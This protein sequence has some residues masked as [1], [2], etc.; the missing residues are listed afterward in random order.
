MQQHLIYNVLNGYCKVPVIF[1]KPFWQLYKYPCNIARFKWNIFEILPRIF[2]MCY[3]GSER[4]KL[5][6]FYR[7][8]LSFKPLQVSQNPLHFLYIFLE[9]SFLEPTNGAK[10]VFLRNLI[11]TIA[12]KDTATRVSEKLGCEAFSCLRSFQ[13]SS[14]S[15][16]GSSTSI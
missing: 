9:I 4:R 6:I 1:Q 11:S 8:L 13:G 10:M 16:E 7:S 14:S 12:S 2:E 3:V 5:L 15:I